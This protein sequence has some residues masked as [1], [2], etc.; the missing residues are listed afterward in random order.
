[1]TAYF[2]EQKYLTGE[3]KDSQYRLQIKLITGDSSQHEYGSGEGKDSV[4]SMVRVIQLL[5][6]LMYNL[7][8]VNVRDHS[9]WCSATDLHQPPTSR[10]RGPGNTA[11]DDATLT[12]RFL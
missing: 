11:A 8:A 3:S 12:T 7:I 4:A 2:E 1:M 5:L 6:R 9:L 10:A